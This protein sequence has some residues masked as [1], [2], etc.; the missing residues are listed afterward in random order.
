MPRVLSVLMAVVLAVSLAA[1]GDDEPAEPVEFGEGEIPRTMPDSIPVPDGAIIGATLIDRVN[2]RTEMT[3]RT[4][5]EFEDLV[6]F[7]AFELVS[8][9][10]LLD[11]TAGD[12]QRWV[13]DFSDG[14]LRGQVVIAP[15]GTGTSQAVVTVN[16]S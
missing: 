12:A 6:R 3:V 16:R 9:G 11:E 8:R 7:Y 15:G 4:R 10:F 2:N 5:F 13:I 1:C 14:D